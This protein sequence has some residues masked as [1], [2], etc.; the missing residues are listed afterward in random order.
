MAQ[1]SKAVTG[2]WNVNVVADGNYEVRIRRWPVE[3]G[4]AIDAELPA[5]ADVPGATPYRA[6]PGKPVPAV[7]ATLTIG[8]ETWKSGKIAP[9][10]HETVFNVSLKAGKTRLSSLF[11]TA[12]DTEYGGYYAYVKRLN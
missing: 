10:D 5:G 1:N 4:A 2:F 7:R 12:D 3:T 9:G 6:R 8:D 11:I